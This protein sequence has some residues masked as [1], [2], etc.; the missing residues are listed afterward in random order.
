V[1][2]LEA[3]RA[4]KTGVTRFKN[5]TL[6]DVSMLERLATSPSKLDRMLSNYKWVGR[7]MLATD[8][9]NSGTA[10]EI[11]Q[12][13]ALRYAATLEG[14]RG[15]Q[16][17]AAIMDA[18][19]PSK[20][21]FD[22][23][24]QQVA[25]E[26]A[27]GVFD[28]ARDKA[29]AIRIRREELLEAG[30]GKDVLAQ[31]TEVAGRWTFNGDPKGMAGF[32]MDGII[33]EKINRSMR[34]TKFFFP[35]MR[36]MA[37]L[38]DTSLDFTPGIGQLRAYNVRTSRLLGENS[39]YAAKKI[40]RGS[41]EFYAQQTKALFGTMAFIAVV[42]AAIKGLED[43]EEGKEPSFGVY[44]AGPEDRYKRD[45]MKAA[46]W[47]PN[48]IKIGGRYMR[49]TDWPALNVVLAAIGAIS[50]YARDARDSST[51]IPTKIGIAMLGA[52]SALT[53]KSA[54]GGMTNIITILANP[55]QRGLNALGRLA[56]GPVGG[57]TNPQL[58]QWLRNT[59]FM[60]KNLQVD[61]LDRSGFDGLMA[62]IVP[63]SIGAD[64]ALNVLGEPLQEYF[65]GATAR[66]FGYFTTIKEHPII[67]PLIRAGLFV[68]SPSKNS[69]IRVAGHEKPMTL[70]RAGQDAF[71]AFLK[72]RGETLKQILNP[73]VI[74][75]LTSMD[76]ELAQSVLDGP[77]VKGVATARAQAMVEADIASGKIKIP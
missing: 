31:G 66:R 16:M 39:K 58:F 9:F 76:R 26:E 38:L 17:E 43:E 36:T 45:Q 46:G 47:L 32:L 25:Q 14:K 1:A 4:I 21:V 60:D 74:G 6:S 28:G 64:T 41:P 5:A 48:S 72:Y 15:Q 40:E 11:R 18:F 30:R 50:D 52:T 8:A 54:L 10:Q 29:V 67:T 77:D 68:P 55:D 51:P 35:F 27:A 23:I 37:N 75:N 34:V 3:L 2:K 62:S 7:V 61:V 71:N 44:G 24:D 22:A 73:E 13:H 49:Y 59:L 56:V 70:G 42:T 57:V 33:N 20:E 65:Y 69:T 19:E 53:E 63:F 12:R